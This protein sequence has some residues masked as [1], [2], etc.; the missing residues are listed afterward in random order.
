MAHPQTRRAH[1]AAV[2]ARVILLVVV[3]ALA[4]IAARST[5]A[6]A[7]LALIATASVPAAL[8]ASHQMHARGLAWRSMWEVGEDLRAGRLIQ[9]LEDCAAPPIG[10]YAVFPQ[11]RHLPLRVRLFIDLLKH[12]YGNPS[13]WSAA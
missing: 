10:I 5:T 4:L 13:Y 9:V 3:S 12:S 11:R 7:W 6:L 1:S 2:A 8:A